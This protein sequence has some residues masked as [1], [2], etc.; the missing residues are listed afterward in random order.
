MNHAV[1]TLKITRRLAHER[2]RVF[3][4]LTD[5]AKMSQWFF[6]PNCGPSTVTN[7]LRPGGKYLIGM[8][9]KEKSPHGTYLEIVPPERIVCTWNSCGGVVDSKVTFELEESDGN[10][11]LT[12]THE[13]P[14]SAVDG[15]RMGWNVCLDHMVLFLDGRPVLAKVAPVA[16]A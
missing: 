2:S 7:D 16:V 12:I 9:D 8:G 10:T 5:P 13:L 11:I 15:H 14:E 6:G 4:A 3:S 1:Q